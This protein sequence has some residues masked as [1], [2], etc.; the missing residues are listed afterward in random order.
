MID[1][2]QHIF[3]IAFSKV[4]S[5]EQFLKDLPHLINDRFKDEFDKLPEFKIVHGG[6]DDAGMV[7]FENFGVGSVMIYEQLMKSIIDIASD[8]Y[9]YYARQVYYNADDDVVTQDLYTND[10]TNTPPWCKMVEDVFISKIDVI[11]ERCNCKEY[12]LAEW[13]KRNAT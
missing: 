1:A 4:A 3:A 13:G 10:E 2:E 6:Y 11:V 8:S 7:Y 9:I 5:A 12:T